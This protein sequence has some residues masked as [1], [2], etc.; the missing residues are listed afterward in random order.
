MSKYTFEPYDV[1][2]SRKEPGLSQWQDF[3]TIRTAD[4]AVF[5]QVAVD[6]QSFGGQPGTFRIVRG[7]RKVVVYS[8][9]EN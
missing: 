9:Q 6:G 2:Q 7:G 4:D 8:R 3:A 1:L 5:A